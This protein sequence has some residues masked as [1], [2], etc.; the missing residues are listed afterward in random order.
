MHG[1]TKILNDVSTRQ[2]Y[3]HAR[4]TVNSK[5]EQ[6][7][8]PLYCYSLDGAKIEEM[9]EIRVAEKKEWQM[10]TSAV[11][12]LNPCIFMFFCFSKSSRVNHK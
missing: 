1:T 5:L 8:E 6:A 11:Q 12:N 7:S 3:P 10:L 2:Q 9:V 4:I